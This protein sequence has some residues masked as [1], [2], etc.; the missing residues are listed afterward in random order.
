[1]EKG[2]GLGAER[3]SVR[4]LPLN[5][6]EVMDKDRASQVAG[7]A[8]SRPAAA[9]D[10]QDLGLILESGR[11]PGGGH[12]NPLQ[13]SCLENPIDRGAWRA[14]G[15]RVAKS[16]TRLKHLSTHARA[17]KS[18]ARRKCVN[19]DKEQRKW[20]PNKVGAGP[21]QSSPLGTGLHCPLPNEPTA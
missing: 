6:S 17:D 7:V 4:P 10:T 14:V 20:G 11:S 2:A 5:R 13:Y 16:R 19:K 8:K 9:G 1:M 18:T 15:H 21:R 3:T 12:G